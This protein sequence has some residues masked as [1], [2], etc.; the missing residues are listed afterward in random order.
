MKRLD[1]GYNR[2]TWAVAVQF[3]C[4]NMGHG[5]SS[6][7]DRFRQGAILSNWMGIFID[8]P[9]NK[10]GMLWIIVGRLGYFWGTEGG[11]E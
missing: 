7:A 11:Q 10:Q 2:E 4:K 3:S 5:V 1:V 9:L 8:W 6:V